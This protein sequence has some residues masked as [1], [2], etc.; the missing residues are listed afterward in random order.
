MY[1]D[2]RLCTYLMTDSPGDQGISIV[3]NGEESELK[4]LTDGKGNKV[5][6]IK[7]TLINTRK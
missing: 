6:R 7:P 4:F 1:H 2:I 3:L 5:K